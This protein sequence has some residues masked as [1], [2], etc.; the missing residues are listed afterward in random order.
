MYNLRDEYF[1]NVEIAYIN[2][3]MLP[4][5]TVA[6]RSKAWLCGRWLAGIAVSSTVSGVDVCLL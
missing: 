3:R 4:S 1:S 5:V 2:T 6:A